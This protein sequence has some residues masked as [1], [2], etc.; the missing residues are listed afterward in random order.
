MDRYV[1]C[2]V[3]QHLYLTVRCT[4]IK[5]NKKKAAMQTMED[6]DVSQKRGRGRGRGQGRGRGRGKRAAEPAVSMPPS[7]STKK[8]GS[9]PKS[10]Q[11]EPQSEVNPEPKSSQREPQSPKVN[12][13][14]PKSSPREPQSP[15]VN[16][17]PKSSPCKPQSP[18]VN[19]EPQS[20]PCK[21]QSPK[22]KRFARKPKSPK[23]KTSAKQA[24]TAKSTEPKKSGKAA[25]TKDSVASE[26]QERVKVETNL[27]RIMKELP[28]ATP[29]S[30]LRHGW[31]VSEF[32]Q[33][34]LVCEVVSSH[35]CPKHT[36]N[37]KPALNPHR[38]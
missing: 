8:E 18:K 4:S 32:T 35:R 12:P 17:E 21:P 37:R 3:L 34:T 10:S 2:A 29:A 28:I 23:P 25:S 31:D 33:K 16:P 30:A 24:K 13:A 20:S 11:R 5:A 6:D 22:L 26:D 9:E 14:E 27:R 19:P 1:Y 36:L 38:G 15:K 7:T